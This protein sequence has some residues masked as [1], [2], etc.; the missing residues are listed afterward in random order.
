MGDQGNTMY[1]GP[2]HPVVFDRNSLRLTI[3][4]HSTVV[5][6]PAHGNEAVLR[7]YLALV[8]EVRGTPIGSGIEVRQDDV[9]VLAEILDLAD[10]DL[11]SHLATLLGVSVEAAVEVHHRLR[12]HRALAAAA[13]VTVGGLALLGA[14][15]VSAE[16]SPPSPAP[17]VVTVP[18]TPVAALAA[19]PSTVVV[20]PAP[21]ASRPPPVPPVTEPQPP[22]I[23][24]HPASSDDVQIG[25]AL[26]IVRGEQPADPATQ[27]GDAVTYER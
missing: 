9:A 10:S 2:R 6:D 24:T 8:A 5:P 3:G 4:E 7:C 18:T 11:D 20:A 27:I 26:V 17:A 12:R 1:V 19:P 21:V 22:V 13:T 25:D 16:P 14:T 23:H 15:K